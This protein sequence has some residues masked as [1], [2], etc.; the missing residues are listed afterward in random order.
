MFDRQSRIRPPADTVTIIDARRGRVRSRIR[1][2]GRPHDVDFSRDGRFLWVTAERGGRLALISVNRGRAVRSVRTSGPPHDLAVDP[3]RGQ[4]WVTIDGSAAVEVRSASNGRLL[5]R[6]VD[7]RPASAIA[8]LDEL[9][10]LAP[11]IAPGQTRRARPKVGA[12]PAPTAWPGASAVIDNIAHG[13][14]GR[15]AMHAVVGPAASGAR[16]I[17]DAAVR[18]W[19]LDQVTRGRRNSSPL[20][21]TR[22]LFR[23]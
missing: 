19:Q 8:L 21:G 7:Q 3:L 14:T 20:F 2:P 22:G 16:A 11:V 6:D 17:V 12:P 15:A 9:D 13:L 1:V 5:A 18:R 10:Q 4:L 23:A